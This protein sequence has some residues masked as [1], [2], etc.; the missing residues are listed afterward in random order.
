MLQDFLLQDALELA[1]LV[2]AAFPSQEWKWESYVPAAQLVTSGLTLGI[3]TGFPFC[4]FFFFFFLLT[5][6][7]CGRSYFQYFV[8]LHDRC[9]W[10]GGNMWNSHQWLRAFSLHCWQVLLLA[11]MGLFLLSS[12]RKPLLAIFCFLF[13]V[14]CK[15]LSPNEVVKT[16]F[17]CCF[18]LFPFLFLLMRSGQCFATA[19][20]VRRLFHLCLLICWCSRCVSE[21]GLY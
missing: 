5:R 10:E 12:Q 16:C 7:D 15:T 2:P 9:H 11:A 18:F 13:P 4:S 19:F 1:S 20:V 17:P 14:D 3:S 21:P 8:L 6:P